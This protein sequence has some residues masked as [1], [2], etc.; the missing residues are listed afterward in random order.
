MKALT[1]PSGLI[2]DQPAKRLGAFCA[3]EW[4][5]YDGL[6]DEN[7]NHITVLDM[8]APVSVNAYAFRGGAGNLRVM[9]QALAVALDPLLP[10]IPV[11]ASLVTFDPELAQF[12]A[13]IRAAVAVPYVLTPVATKVLFRKR[14]E[15]VPMLDNVMIQYY[16]KALGRTDL[17]AASQDKPRAA[18][19]AKVCT[20]AFRVDLEAAHDELR[21]FAAATAALGCPIGPV[22][23]LEVLIWSEVEERGYYRGGDKA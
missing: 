8:L 18:G 19:V 5:Y 20:A 10:A 16:L 2:I 17:R 11:D 4:P 23:A 12:E 22:R 9:H 14:R 13:L 21:E 3:A 15:F 7:P 6:A 1:L